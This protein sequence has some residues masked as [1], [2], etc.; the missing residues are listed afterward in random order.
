[1]F[2]APTTAWFADA[3][4][5]PTRVQREGWPA[6]AAGDHTLL[7]APTGSGKTL[8]AFLAALDRLVRLPIGAPPAVRVLYVSPLKALV[9]DIERNLRAPLI[10]L[11]NAAARLGQPI[12]PIRVDVRTGDTTSRERRAQARDPADIL[13]TTPESLYLLLGSAAR[14]ALVHVD[15]VIVDEIHV[16]AGT[17]RG[18]HLALSLE[19]LAARCEREPQRVGL[20]ATQRPL[21]EIARFLGGDRPVRIVDTSE[22]P[23]LILQVVVPVPDMEHPTV[24]SDAATHFNDGPGQQVGKKRKPG[25]SVLAPRNDPDEKAKMAAGMWPAVYPKLLELIRAHRSTIV[26]TNSRL[27]CER[28]AQRL[29]ELAGEELVRA[30]HGSISHAARSQI[31]EALK[32]GQL[33]AIIAT[34]SLELGID[35]GS[36]DLVILVE[37]PGSVARGLQRVGRAGHQVGGTS[38]GRIFPKFRGDLVEC[39][40][41]AKHMLDGKIESTRVPR[42]CLDVLSQQIVAMA[43]MDD[44]K[45]SE[46]YRLVQRSY[47]YRD[48]GKASFDAVLDMLSGRY[49][50]DDFAELAPRVVW[51]RDQDVLRG[52]RGAQMLALTSGG[53]IPDRGLYTVTLG[54]KGPRL[55]E[56]DE[57]MVYETRRGDR[58]I[59]GA[60]TWRVE[61]VTRD[62]VVVSPAPGEPGKLPFWHGDS[63]GRPIE[64]GRELGA[65]LGAMQGQSADESKAYLQGFSP[66]DD[67]AIKNLVAYVEEQ[68]AATGALPS[69]RSVVVEK[70]RDE[71]GEWRVCILTPFGSRVHA[72]WAMAIQAQLAAIGGF[73]VQTLYTDDGIALRFADVDTLP[74]LDALLPDPDAVEDLVVEQLAASALFAARFRENAA[75]ALL[76]PRRRGGART[77]LWAQRLRS[78]NLQAVAQKFPSFPIILETY[79]ECLQ[80]IFDVPS[81]VDLLRALRSRAIGITEVETP[82]ASPFARSLVFAW[83]AAYMYAGDGPL[84]ERRAA[85][86]SLNRGLLRELLGQEELREL[87]DPEAVDAVEA[88]LQWTAEDRRARHADGLADLLR[89]VGELDEGEIAARFEGDPSA[90]LRDLERARR[91]IPIRLG[92]HPRWL[93]VEDAGRYRDALGAVIPGGLP[94]VFLES[95]PDPLEGLLHRWARTHGPFLAAPLAKRWGLPVPAVEAVLRALESRGVLIHG[96]MRPGGTDPEWCDPDVLRRLRQRSLAALRHEIAPV[97]PEVYARF[98]PRWHGIGSTRGGLPRLRE[99]I[100][101]LEGVPLPYS[102][103]EA[104]LLPARVPDFRPQMLDD[105]GAMGFVVWIGAGGLGPKDGKVALYRRERVPLLLDP[106]DGEVEDPVQ[107]AILAHLT[108]R[109][110]SFLTELQIAVDTALPKEPGVRLAPASFRRPGTPGA[111]STGLADLQAALWALAWDGRITNDTFLPLRSLVSRKASGKDKLTAAGGRWAAVA[112]LVGAPPDATLRAHARANALLERYGVATAAAAHAD[113]LPG[114]FQAVYPVLRAMEDAGRARRGLFVDG[115]GGAQFA[116]A[117]AVDR[118]RACRAPDESALVLSATDPANPWGSLVPWP[119]TRARRVA[120]AQVVLVG[121]QPAVFVEKGEKSWAT[122]PAAED[123]ATLVRAITAWLDRPGRKLKAVRIDT[124][125]GEPA[126]NSPHAPAFAEA[127]FARGYQSLE[128]VR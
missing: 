18:V 26:F 30:H 104:E 124:I 16:L 75:R 22:K 90:A 116:L 94:A 38:I 53:T 109:G 12:R 83:V 82:S 72:P 122:F 42:N 37:S 73:E 96:A 102:V 33:P 114:G 98:L 107:R 46:L 44:W 59:L 108:S 13:V 32:A 64:L 89:R 3:F 10:G 54:P 101:Q 100:E 57:E 23:R 6:I 71:L 87:L 58:I 113:G 106:P 35:M 50:S 45:I 63:V 8:A 65:M 125:D 67:F 74:E 88:E 68:K 20:S 11:Q 55:G 117:G 115:L 112:G 91:I 92:G 120:G 21:E 14:E 19:R 17:K 34:S 24:P 2:S 85:A 128:R 76:L 86:L 127:G 7:L 77:P 84:A 31:E 15:T 27:L 47:P 60:S 81:L 40:V 51:D 123:R 126:P 62:R 56:L 48:L 111:P 52:R 80:E 49:P 99:V 5:A 4:A 118:L 39:A 28:L 121:G 78:Q 105:L 61:E 93:A 41:V 43:S 1:M 36:V 25:G 103:L 110:A 95:P 97:E 70:F 79:R 9:A 119:G 69:D 66:L 29:N